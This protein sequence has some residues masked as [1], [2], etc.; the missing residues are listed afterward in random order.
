MADKITKL[1]LAH[2]LKANVGFSL[3]KSR[4]YV[5]IVFGYM[6]AGLRRDDKLVI[7]SF[8]TFNVHSKK[9]RIGRNLNTGEPCKITAR[10]I[11]TFKKSK[12]LDVTLT[13]QTLQTKQE[14][15]SN[16]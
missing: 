8:G 7:A 2:A 6:L 3:D 14:G 9:E 11:V 5:E 12:G 1:T 10:K 15:K 16:P 4:N 13:L